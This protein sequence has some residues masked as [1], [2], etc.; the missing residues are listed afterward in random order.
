MTRQEAVDEIMAEFKTQRNSIAIGFLVDIQ[1]KYDTSSKYRNKIDAEAI[2][3][4]KKPKHEITDEELLAMTIRVLKS[5]AGDKASMKMMKEN[6]CDAIIETFN[7]KYKHNWNFFVT[8]NEKGVPTFTAEEKEDTRTPEQRKH[9]TVN[10]MLNEATANIITESVHDANS[11]FAKMQKDIARARTK[12]LR[13]LYEGL[14]EDQLEAFHETVMKN[15]HGEKIKI[16]TEDVAKVAHT[17]RTRAGALAWQTY[18]ESMVKKVKKYD[19]ETAPEF[20]K[21]L[22]KFKKRLKIFLDNQDPKVASDVIMQSTFYA[23]G[24]VNLV[25]DLALADDEEWDKFEK[26]YEAHK[27]QLDKKFERFCRNYVDDE[28]NHPFRDTKL[29]YIKPQW[30]SGVDVIETSM[31]VKKDF[32]TENITKDVAKSVEDELAL[33]SMYLSNNMTHERTNLTTGQYET[34]KEGFFSKSAIGLLSDSKGN[35]T[36]LRQNK[37]GDVKIAH[38]HEAYRLFEQMMKTYNGCIDEWVKD[39]KKKF[40]TLAQQYK[41]RVINELDLIKGG[42]YQ[43]NSSG[44]PVFRPPKNEEEEKWVKRMQADIENTKKLFSEP[45][46]FKNAI[47]KEMTYKKNQ[48]EF[49]DID[50][51]LDMV[52]NSAKTLEEAERMVKR[53]AKK[54]FNEQVAYVKKTTGLDLSYLWPELDLNILDSVYGES[55]SKLKKSFE[56]VASTKKNITGKSANVVLGMENIFATDA[57]FSVKEKEF[58]K[59]SGKSLWSYNFGFRNEAQVLRTSGLKP[60]PIPEE[61]LK[62]KVIYDI[63]GSI[64]AASFFQILVSNTPV[65]EVYFYKETRTY[66]IA[67]NAML[68]EKVEDV[69]GEDVWVERN[70]RDVARDMYKNKRTVTKEYW[71]KHEPDEDSVRNCWEFRYKGVTFRPT[72]PEFEENSYDLFVNKC[73]AVAIAIIGKIFRDR[74]ANSKSKTDNFTYKNTNKRWEQLE[75]GGYKKDTPG[76][77]WKGRSK[78]GLPHGVKNQYTYQAPFGYLRLIEAQ[79][80][81]LI[82]DGFDFTLTS[83]L[84]NAEGFNVTTVAKEV[85]QD[86]ADFSNNINTNEYDIDNFVIIEGGGK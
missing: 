38:D 31:G 1:D 42:M 61:A 22:R 24:F 25:P 48:G 32:W 27:R 55:F 50:D 44:K 71:R 43:D 56:R 72:D 19:Y 28:G 81:A 37:K 69:D 51:F 17:K 14:P 33:A 26:E 66:E 13:G 54:L 78:Y 62:D 30:R 20:H 9:E 16:N 47:G 70:P 84:I 58:Y 34:S 65:D 73:D 2:A 53:E 80:N 85:A 57:M 35:L 3:R 52:G 86:L 79:W 67:G 83:Q 40:E 12:E 60:M 75:Y 18:I 29:V 74:T 46:I 64:V 41:E 77:P 45:N 10:Q 8:F 11:F 23:S 82:D 7:N 4:I 68:S 76:A 6:I 63:Y 15:W 39:Q 21:R 49:F 36:Y 5:K 59:K